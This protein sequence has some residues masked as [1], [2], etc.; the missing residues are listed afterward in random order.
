MAVRATHDVGIVEA[1]KRDS[2]VPMGLEKLVCLFAGALL[3]GCQLLGGMEVESVA[4][5]VQKPSNVAV[6]VKVEGSDGPVTDLHDSDFTVLE[7]GLELDRNQVGLTLLPKEQSTAHHVLVLVDLSGPAEEQ[8]A[9]PLLAKQLAPFI[10][11]LRVDHNVSLYG[12]DGSDKL[13]ALGSF[14]RLMGKTD[15]PTLTQT[16]LIAVAQYQQQDPSSNLHGAVVS[17]LHHLEL[18]LLKQDKPVSVGTMV[19][20]ARGPDLAAR[21]SESQMLDALRN[22][23]RHVY[24][25]TVGSEDD[26]SLAEK[27]G[28]AGYHQASL[29]ENLELSLAEV[30][31]L[32][33]DDYKRYYLVAYCSPSRAG[34][35]TLLVRVT[36]R[37][38]DGSE[39]QG[40][41]ELEFDATGFQ[42]GCTSTTPP[43][44]TKAGLVSA[45][46]SAT[47]P[48]NPPSEPVSEDPEE[49]TADE[50]PVTEPEG[51]PSDDD[52]A[53]TDPSGSPPPA[54][55]PAETPAPAG[56][57]AP[58]PAAP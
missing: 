56:A 54:G 41:A 1:M 3:W 38:G 33:E 36:Q 37:E 48:A 49:G 7:N 18:E 6:Y 57:P 55:A 2:R 42:A 9:L 28:P 8:G 53:A 51:S 20:I 13:T 11:R 39:N 58:A 27:I 43:T 29:F 15:V 47:P 4:S 21:T 45:A 22:T 24:A 12:F 17:G 52:A 32:V 26:T 14:P 10:E 5:S 19:I 44:F 50:P 34:K 30:A 35:R 31:R 46:P 40:E 16:D 23:R 25:V